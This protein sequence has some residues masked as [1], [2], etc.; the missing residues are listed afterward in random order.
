MVV[1]DA[2][3]DVVDAIHVRHIGMAADVREVAVLAEG[4]ALQV[5]G[6]VGKGITARVVVKSIA[7][8]EASNGEQRMGA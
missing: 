5:A 7:T 1:L 3:L 4:L 8:D 6:E 2:G